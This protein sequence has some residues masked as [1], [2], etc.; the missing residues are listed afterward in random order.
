M[1]AVVVIFGLFILGG[2]AIPFLGA[3]RIERLAISVTTW[4]GTC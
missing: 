3:A 4:V 2:V 1:S